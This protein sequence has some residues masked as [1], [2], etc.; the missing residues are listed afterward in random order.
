MK[1]VDNGGCFACG[2]ANDCGLHLSFDYRDGRLKVLYKTEERFQGYKDILHGGI[3]ATLIDEAASHLAFR[4]GHLTVTAEIKIKYLKPVPIGE[5]ISVECEE[6]YLRGKILSV[7][8]AVCSSSG[9]PLAS[10]EVLLYIIGK[11]ETLQKE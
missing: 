4:K 3:T 1:L 7:S 10:G 11:Y 5:I 2:S 9:I 8:S 6:K